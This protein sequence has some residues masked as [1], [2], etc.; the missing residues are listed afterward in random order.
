MVQSNARNGTRGRSKSITN[1]R[2]NKMST[3]VVRKRNSRCTSTSV[4]GV[5]MWSIVAD[6]SRRANRCMKRIRTPCVTNPS[7]QQDVIE[8]TWY[9][10]QSNV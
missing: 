7:N 3:T 8:F 9:G 5:D 10:M 6:T 1:C 4:V 2:S